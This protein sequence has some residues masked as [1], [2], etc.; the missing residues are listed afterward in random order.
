MIDERYNGERAAA[1]GGRT[2]IQAFGQTRRWTD[3][4]GRTDG[5][6]DGHVADKRI[7]RRL[8]GRPVDERTNSRADGRTG[9]QTDIRTDVSSRADIGANV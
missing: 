8:D 1:D 6:T 9:R 3:V 7:G 4:D 5:R 2:D